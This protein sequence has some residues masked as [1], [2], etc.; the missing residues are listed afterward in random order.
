VEQLPPPAGLGR[1]VGGRAGRSDDSNDVGKDGVV[2]LPRRKVR[3]AALAVAAATIAAIGLGSVVVDSFQEEPPPSVAPSLAER[4]AA[5]PDAEEVV[6]EFPDGAKATVVRSVELGRA[7]IVTENMPAPPPGT[8]DQLWF[9]AVRRGMVPAGTM[10]VASDQTFLL[11]GAAARAE[12]VGITVEPEE[13]STA[14][15]SQPIA[16]FDFEP[17]QT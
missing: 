8:V 1:G 4:I 2:M 11:Q 3:V 17:A 12:A 7:M 14:P 15:T 13:G 10:P 9:D 6:V 16:L 5:A